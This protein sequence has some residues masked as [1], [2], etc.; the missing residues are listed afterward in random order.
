[1]TTTLS[2]GQALQTKAAQLEL[3]PGEVAS[4]AGVHPDDA[5]DVLTGTP[6]LWAV[7]EC[8]ARVL[9]VTISDGVRDNYLQE[10]R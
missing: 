9:H 7:V 6:A 2:L 8:V 3:S 1:M 5:A 10:A 4:R